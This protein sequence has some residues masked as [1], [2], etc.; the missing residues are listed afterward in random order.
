MSERD[1]VT[2][3]E[4]LEARLE[5]TE[6]ALGLARVELERRL[7]GMNEFRE[8][9]RDQA[10]RFITRDEFDMRMDAM[11][12]RREAGIHALEVKVEALVA[13]MEADR[14]VV[15]GRIDAA[16]KGKVSWGVALAVTLLSSLV[17]LL[18]V[19]VVT[20]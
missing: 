12:A 9:L 2:L 1:E 15:C 13:R 10:A 18:I 20:H 8:Q 11:V 7:E 4:L 6:K 16:A 14:E 19:W 5:A 17:L 3:R